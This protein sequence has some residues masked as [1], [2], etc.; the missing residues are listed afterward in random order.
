MNAQPQLKPGRLASCLSNRRLEL[1]VMP[2]ERCNFRC[3]YCYEDFLLGRMSSDTIEGIR[4][5]ISNRIEKLDQLYI[6]WFGGEPLAAADI[7]LDLSSHAAEL[8]SRRPMMSYR[9]GIT[10]NGYFVNQQLL[11]QM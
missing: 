5:L 4:A 9:A 6:S 1:I 11:D 8:A 10:T 7:M 3:T 2:T